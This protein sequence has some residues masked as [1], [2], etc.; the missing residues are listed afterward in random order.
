MRIIDALVAV[1][2][3]RGEDPALRANVDTEGPEIE[4]MIL[5][6]PSSWETESET[7]KFAELALAISAEGGPATRQFT[8]ACAIVTSTARANEDINHAM[9][10][11]LD[12]IGRD[13]AIAESVDT[14]WDTM[15]ETILTDGSAPIVLNTPAQSRAGSPNR[16]PRPG[17]RDE[18]ARPALFKE[19]SPKD[20]P[21]GV[22]GYAEGKGIVHERF[23]PHHQRIGS[24]GSHA[25]RLPGY[26]SGERGKSRTKEYLLQ[27]EQRWAA[28]PQTDSRRVAW[29]TRW[30]GA[31][32]RVGT[33]DEFLVVSDGP[34][35]WTTLD[36]EDRLVKAWV[37]GGR[38]NDGPPAPSD[39][40]KLTALNFGPEV[41]AALHE[42][43]RR[44][45]SEPAWEA[46]MAT[47]PMRVNK[48]GTA[49]EILLPLRSQLPNGSTETHRTRATSWRWL[50]GAA[51]S[52]G[53]P[54][55]KGHRNS[56]ITSTEGAIQ[57]LFQ[58]QGLMAMAANADKER[59]PKGKYTVGPGGIMTK[60]FIDKLSTDNHQ[61]GGIAAEMGTAATVLLL[62]LTGEVKRGKRRMTEIERLREELAEATKRARCQ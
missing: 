28:L 4:K 7:I 31:R 16:P 23:G 32:R 60:E 35:T 14:M 58:N 55:N 21:E 56:C 49:E 48:S 18:G 10:A 45:D 50:A 9:A 8:Y 57:H 25:P 17:R 20:T 62:A 40:N 24:G 52:N 42:L 2:G 30:V 13:E 12:G 34:M 53:A 39:A 37:A 38:D 22:E 47:P 11:E 27:P 59:G 29:E 61:H 5:G 44:T 54:G 15:F 26:V 6:L 3:T 33:T 51:A 36:A 46:L 1:L 41:D 43:A 19:T